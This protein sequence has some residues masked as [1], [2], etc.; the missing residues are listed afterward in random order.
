MDDL[1]SESL[2]SNS[3]VISVV[4]DIISGVV[5]K[6]SGNEIASVVEGNTLTKDTISIL[7]TKELL[8]SLKEKV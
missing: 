7:A 6:I 1:A 3:L 2:M 8:A 5:D 4:T